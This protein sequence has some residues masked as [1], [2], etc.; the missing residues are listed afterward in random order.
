MCTRTEADTQKCTHRHTV[1]H[2]HTH[3]E[4]HIKTHMETHIIHTCKHT[5]AHRHTHTDR[6]RHRHTHKQANTD[7]ETIHGFK[8]TP[9]LLTR[10]LARVLKGSRQACAAGGGRR[11]EPAVL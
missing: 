10:P 4:R 7:M 5:E 8:I 1:T 6:G 11:G 2:R 9:G 3:P